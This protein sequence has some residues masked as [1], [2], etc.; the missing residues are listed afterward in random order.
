MRASAKVL[1]LLVVFVALPAAASAQAVIAG[2]VKDPSGGVLPG[3]VVEA[4]SPALIEKVR[5][6]VTDGTG[7]YRV[8][9][10]RPGVY[11]VTFTL[12]GFS[13]YRREGIELTGSFTATVNADLRVGA[14]AETVTVT[15]E[16]PV[17]DVQSTR[18]EVTLN[19]EVIKSIPTVR[20]YNAMVVV[21]PGVVTNLNDTVT[22]TATTQFPI[23]GGRNN[24]G[25]LTIDGLN[26][27]NPA[28][29]NQPPQYTADIG[30]SQE[31][32]FTTSGGLGESETAGLVMNIVPKTGGNNVQGSIYFSGTG[33]SLQ[34]DNF[35]QEIKDAGLAAPTPFSKV[36]DLNGAVGGPLKKDRVWFFMNA[37][38][39]GSTRTVA[40]VF[41]NLNAG[42]ATKWNYAPD[43]NRPAYTDKTWENV[44][45]RVTWQATPRNKVGVFWD[46]QRICR[47]CTGLTQGITDPARVSPEAIGVGLLDPM[48]VFQTTWSSPRTNRLLLDAGFGATQYGSGNPERPGN[49]TRDLVRVTEQCANGCAANGNIPGLVYRSQDWGDAFSGAYNWRAS[50]AY[51]TGAHSFKIGYQGT[52]L[53]DDRT[54]STNNLNLAYR[55]NN[56]VPNQL[57]ELISP[58]VNNSRAGWHALFAQEQWTI[59][60]LTL[61]GALRFDRAS[62][63]FP[64]QREGPSR[65]LPT[66]V[67]YP[68][69]KGV[70]AY[71]DIT[72]RTGIAFDVFG[73]G[74]TALKFNVGKYLEGVGAQLN[75]V[76]SNPS[77]RAP[78]SLT[79][80]G[81]AGVTRTWTDANNNFQPDCDLSNPLA[82]DQRATGGD[83][84]GSLSNLSFG[85][86][87]LT[88]NFDPA[89]LSG[90]GVRA[91]DWSLGLSL[92]QQLLPR[93]SI[94]VA[95]QRRWFNGFTVNNNLFTSQSDYSSYSVTAPLD[96]RLPGGGGYVVSNL[97]DVSPALSGQ[98]NNLT[99]D[100]QK[101]GAWK[102]NFNGVDITLNV[103]TRAGLTFQGGTSTG[104]S[105]GDN[106]EVRSNLPELNAA[107]VQ[108]LPGQTS[109]GVSL[110]N[111][112]CH[113]DYGWLTQVRGLTSYTIPRVDVQVSGIFQSKPGV[114]L[115]ANYAVPASV[116]A[117]SLGR[118]PSGNVTNVTVNLIA[119]GSMYGDRLNELD[120]GI[121]K[122]VR[123]GRTRTKVG[124][125]IY[126]VMN[127]SAILTYNNVFVPGGPWLQPNSVLTG[128]LVRISAQFDF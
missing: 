18:R 25:R 93:M 120:L 17:V 29:G 66:A 95:Y 30:N 48:R 64:E 9:D 98:I 44:S 83:F 97:Y 46:E 22:G 53:T 73:N 31:V 78:S 79:I 3:V 121:A 111:P 116:V 59:G 20:S 12:P 82:T 11:T 54:Y 109:S 4:A 125:D 37:R 92:Q 80:F 84:C 38:T 23:H 94:E 14:L 115:S 100:S 19:S 88:N 71:K 26:I 99:T 112:Y 10:L 77:L 113:V 21:V 110:A 118:L 128:R 34:A 114:L 70:D 117:Q 102:N 72:P 122:I 52:L 28:G 86:N 41:Y 119:P 105:A 81:P 62:S 43:L 56:G 57:T 75:Y 36:Y 50:F 42:D 27:G 33:E 123:F 124:A 49:V 1:L 60:R 63:W 51:V 55:L 106:C 47:K 35:T 58:W 7:Q 104:Q 45:G 96:A 90:W 91:S 15:G 5:S 40:N 69:T 67:V 89:L 24:E 2:T 39:Q 65:F 61:Q 68:E 8:E 85:Q 127:S 103:R 101:F 13:T 32:T 16:T 108:G 76:N 107:L 6:A 74:R 87:V 126:N